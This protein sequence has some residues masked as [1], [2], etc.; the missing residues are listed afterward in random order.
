MARCEAYRMRKPFKRFSLYAHSMGGGPR[1]IGTAGPEQGIA[2]K[3][4]IRY[5]RSDLLY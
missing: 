3:K 1:V 2:L 5:R 4:D